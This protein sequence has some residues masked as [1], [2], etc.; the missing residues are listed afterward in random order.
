M[1]KAVT[2]VSGLCQI[3]KKTAEKETFAGIPSPPSECYAS[4]WDVIAFSDYIP[5]LLQDSHYTERGFTI[6]VPRY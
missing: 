2:G 1:R 6:P 5:I 3:E 4:Q